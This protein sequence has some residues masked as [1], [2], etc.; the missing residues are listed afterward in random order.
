MKC[1]PRYRSIFEE[2]YA[3]QEFEDRFL[4]EPEKGV[5][6]IIPT[7][8]TNE[9]WNANLISIYREI[10]VAK[11]LIADG[12]CIDDTVAI[13]KKYPRVEVHD[14]RAYKTLGYSI[15]LLIEAVET[16]WFIYLHSDVYLPQ[17]WFDGM[18]RH[19]DKYDW[20]GCRMGHTVMV[21][22]EV[23]F[24]ERPWAGSQMGRKSA[25]N[26]GLE[27]IEDDFVYR[28]EDFVFA[29]IVKS[30]GLKEGK[31]DDVWHYHQTM[32]KPGPFARR[33]TDV[34]IGV[35]MSREEEIRTWD[36]QVKGIVK[37]LRPEGRWVMEDAAVG[38]HKL[39]KLG[40][41]TKQQIFDWI[42]KENPAW[43]PVIRRRL[44]KLMLVDNLRASARSFKRMVR[45]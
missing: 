7:V 35:D 38:T 37:Y 2:Y 14:H 25:F 9:L 8:H 10:P 28:Q 36:M 31:I 22:Y 11:L 21:E 27:R 24:G 40:A 17:G 45:L 33:V 41:Y 13:A 20:Y 12:G 44:R 15:R 18:H 16:E 29:D 30:A 26:K 34:K 32:R 23:D 1:H 3:T 4:R 42:E 6:V 19:A 5:T 39:I 43:L